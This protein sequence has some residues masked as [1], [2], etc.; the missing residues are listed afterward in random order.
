MANEAVEQ[1]RGRVAAGIEWLVAHDDSGAFHHW[2]VA[3]LTALSPMP[4][5]SGDR[6]EA[7]K[8]YVRQRRRWEQ[9]SKD[10]ERLDPTWRTTT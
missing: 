7:W 1:L 4:A 2:F 9:M 10:L 6:I 5:Q 3:G 8:E